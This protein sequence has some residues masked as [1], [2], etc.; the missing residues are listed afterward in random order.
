MN[1]EARIPLLNQVPIDDW[2]RLQCRRPWFDSWV[3]RKPWIRHW[4]PKNLPAM[5]KTWVRPLGWEDPLEEGMAIHSSILAWRIP[6]DR[7][8]WWATVYGVTTNQTH[9]EWSKHSITPGGRGEQGSGYL[10]LFSHY[11]E[12]ILYSSNCLFIL[13]QSRKKNKKIGPQS[14]FPHLRTDSW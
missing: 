4:L 12:P 7:E 2:I 3:R 5:Q 14:H 8:A 6:T 13:K 11:A 9:L 10:N 1:K